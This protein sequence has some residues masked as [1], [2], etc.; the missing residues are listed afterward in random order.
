MFESNS[1]IFRVILS[2]L[3]S[4]LEI[5]GVPECDSNF[6]YFSLAPE[7]LLQ[8]PCVRAQTTRKLG[9]REGGAEAT[10]E[11]RKSAEIHGSSS[12]L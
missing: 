9:V 7:P 4:N 11:T 12:S 3:W 2:S 5:L 6:L 10:Q 1:E 8:Y